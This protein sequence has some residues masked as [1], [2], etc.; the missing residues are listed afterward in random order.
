MFAVVHVDIHEHC[1]DGDDD[2]IEQIL[3]V[4]DRGEPAG[5]GLLI[6]DADLSRSLGGLPDDYEKCYD[7]YC[8]IIHHQGE[9]CFVR[10]PLCL[11]KG[12]DKAPDCSCPHACDHHADDKKGSRQLIAQADHAGSRRQ[13][14]DHDLALAAYI[15]ETHAKGRRHSKG[16]TK[17]DSHLLQKHPEPSGSPEI[18][19]EH[20]N[21]DLDRVI[22]RHSL[23]NDAADDQSGDQGDGADAP[24]LV[25][26]HLASLDYMKQGFSVLFLIHL[27]LALQGKSS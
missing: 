21:V 20:G 11:E 2:D 1:D 27:S 17:E 6:Y 24:C 14:A 26:G 12:R 5:H 19:Q 3:V 25:P 13:A 18:A 22:P 23:S 7:L 4:P 16:N 9:K 10:I 8:D 15:P